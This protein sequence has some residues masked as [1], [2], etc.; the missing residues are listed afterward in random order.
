MRKTKEDA[1][2]TREILL[3]AAFKVFSN[4][5]YS[6]AS[7]VEV[8]KEAG[9]T[10]GAV[11]WHFGCKYQLFKELLS[12]TYEEIDK[13]MQDAAQKATSALQKIRNILSRLIILVSEKPQFRAMEEI[14]VFGTDGKEGMDKL[15]KQHQDRTV[16]WRERFEKLIQEGFE[17]GEIDESLDSN[18]ISMWMYSFLSGLHSILPTFDIDLSSEEQAQKMADIFIGGIAKRNKE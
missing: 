7:L 14:M 17:S 9:V 10:R 16:Q 13:M 5:G 3:D 15:Y 6:R 8:A 12:E 11:Y 4:K 1:A 2:Q 18:M